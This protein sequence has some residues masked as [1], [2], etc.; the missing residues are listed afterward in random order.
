ML[1][2]EWLSAWSYHPLAFLVVLAAI[3]TAIWLLGVRT[4]NWR[5]ISRQLLDQSLLGAA[6]AFLVVWAIRIWASALPPVTGVG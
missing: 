3:G 6:A 5:P 1:R 2:G 4:W